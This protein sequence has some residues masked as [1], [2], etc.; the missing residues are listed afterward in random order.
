MQIQPIQASTPAAPSVQSAEPVSLSDRV[1]GTQQSAPTPAGSPLALNDVEAWIKASREDI[2]ADPQAMGK[3]LDTI[4]SRLVNPDGSRLVNSF[5]DRITY[6]S[7]FQDLVCRQAGY[8]DMK[9][10]FVDHSKALYG[11][12]MFM[13]DIITK[14]MNP[15]GD[16]NTPFPIEW[17]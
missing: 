1:A 11:I 6:I 4:I 9:D 17:E 13:Q 2:L 10:F 5:T 15:L 16:P 12:N 7:Y 8:E 14:M 3:Q